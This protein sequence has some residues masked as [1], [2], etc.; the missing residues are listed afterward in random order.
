MHPDHRR[1]ARADID[2]AAAA[3]NLAVLK[4]AAPGCQMWAVVKA[5][6]YGHGAIDI[7]GAL[8]GAD[9]FCVALV[10]EGLELR[11]AGVEA[12]ILVL[13]EQPPDQFAD[14]L[15][16]GLQMVVY[17]ESTVDA[18]AAVATTL[19]IV[20]DVH[21]HI[22]SGMSRVG[23]RP[24]MALDRVRQIVG[25]RH[26]RLVGTMTHLA[27][28]DQP[29]SGATDQQLAVFTEVLDRIR[30]A[31]ID[32]G[33]VHA[34]NS[35]ATLVAP[36]AHFDL[37]R[38]GIALYGISPGVGADEAAA[39]LSPVMRLSARVSHVARVPAG[40]HVS[41]GWRYEVPRPTTLATIPIGYADG[42]V[43]ALGSDRS[44]GPGFAV[45]VG[46]ERHPIVGVVTMD[47]TIIDVGDTEVEIG[48]EVVLIGGQ[49]SQRIRAEDWADRLDTIG[50]EIVCG[51][52]GRV[53]RRVTGR[54][55][56]PIV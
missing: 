48:D 36:Q 25:H 21:V 29:S 42:V 2:T 1:W 22:D 50:Y 24:E 41:Y 10:Q 35:A 3:H 44:G 56:P 23:V 43:R 11:T 13:T 39:E 33:L 52:S 26:L 5:N 15:G 47:Q 53:P 46:G 54:F 34:A 55:G 8:S 45:L 27:C 49:G 17:N 28:A 20:A 40:T 9:G 31:G 18:L 32:P 38:P 51:I 4:T 19:G 30:A 12:P 7:A 6:G 14:A 16:A 37:V